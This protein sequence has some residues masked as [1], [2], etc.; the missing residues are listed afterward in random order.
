M[1]ISKERRRRFSPDSIPN[2]RPSSRPPPGSGCAHP[3]NLTISSIPSSA[4]SSRDIHAYVH[5][6]QMGCT[7]LTFTRHPCLRTIPLGIDLL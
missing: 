5:I 3:T 7:T 2:C 4:H 1:T 6:S